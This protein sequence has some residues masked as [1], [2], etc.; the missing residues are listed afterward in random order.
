MVGVDGA[1][2]GAVVTGAAVAGGVGAAAVA[3]GDVIVGVGA[4]AAATGVDAR[5]PVRPCSVARGA[6]VAAAAAT[7]TSVEVV[8]GPGVVDV[9]TRTVTSGAVV[10][11]TAGSLVAGCV[12]AGRTGIRYGCRA[13]SAPSSSSTRFV[14]VASPSALSSTLVLTRAA[15]APAARTPVAVSTEASDGCFIRWRP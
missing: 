1:A 7:A 2:R 12:A 11:V 13:W 5:P 3:A 15:V 8:A 14:P 9:V 4:G 10:T 6:V